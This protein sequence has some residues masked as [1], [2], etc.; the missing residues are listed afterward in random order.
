MKLHRLHSPEA[1][2]VLS[3]QK[4]EEFGFLK[5]KFCERINAWENLGHKKY[6]FCGL[7][8]IYNYGSHTPIYMPNIYN[9]YA[10][11]LFCFPNLYESK[12][13]SVNLMEMTCVLI[14]PNY[15]HDTLLL[16]ITS[17]CGYLSIVW[18]F[19]A[20]GNLFILKQAFHLQKVLN[21]AYQHQ[22]QCYKS[23]RL[24]FSWHKALFCDKIRL[25]KYYI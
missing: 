1:S 21:K 18:L 5:G 11:V 16:S 22:I 14:K 20:V 23:V 19:Q 12:T 8:V 4:K 6:G 10:K 3:T 9:I 13:T 24:I 2:L 25:R 7:F 15:R 17:L